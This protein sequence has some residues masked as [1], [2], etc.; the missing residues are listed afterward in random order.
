M[1]SPKRVSIF[2]FDDIEVLD[3][4]GPFEVFSVAAEISDPT[5]FE[6]ELVSTSLKP[7]RTR[8]GMTVLPKRTLAECTKTDLLIIPGGFGTRALLKDKVVADWIRSIHSETE[9]TLSVCTGSLLLASAGILKGKQATSHQGSL[10]FLGKFIGP[11]NVI[12]DQ[13]FVEDGKV[14]TSGGIAAGID[15]SLHVIEKLCGPE[16]LEKVQTEMEYP[17]IPKS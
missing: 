9:L 7:I 12:D 13:R 1:N 5:A 17:N 10:K 4:C 2:V 3:F 6:V 14:I 8:G 11:E 16:L 15:M